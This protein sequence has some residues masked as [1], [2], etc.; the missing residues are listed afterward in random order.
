MM[1]FFELKIHRRVWVNYYVELL[2]CYST[3]HTTWMHKQKM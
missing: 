3:V 1:N 2:Q